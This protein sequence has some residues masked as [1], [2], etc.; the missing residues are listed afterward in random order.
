LLGKPIKNKREPLFRSQHG[1]PHDAI[2]QGIVIPGVPL[3]EKT[4]NSFVFEPKA[5]QMKR[6]SV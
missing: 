6:E 5:V 2:S 1:Y 3:I 4:S